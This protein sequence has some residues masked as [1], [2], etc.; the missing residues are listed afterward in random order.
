MSSSIKTNKDIESEIQ[1]LFNGIKEDFN[2]SRLD[3]LKTG[4]VCAFLEYH[5]KLYKIDLGNSSNGIENLVTHL[6]GKVQSNDPEKGYDTIKNKVN[7]T[8]FIKNS[9]TKANLLR[10]YLIMLERLAIEIKE[11]AE[12]TITPVSLSKLIASITAFFYHNS[13]LSSNTESELGNSVLSVYDFTAGWGVLL[14]AFYEIPS[15]KDKLFFSLDDSN[16][17]NLLIAKTTILLAANGKIMD[18]NLGQ[19]NEKEKPLAFLGK[20]F[21]D[22]LDN[23]KKLYD[24]VITHPPFATK[25]S[26][27]KN[28]LKEERKQRFSEQE[29]G[30]KV[31]DSTPVGLFIQHAVSLLSEGGIAA[32]V[33]PQGVLF[34]GNEKFLREYFVSKSDEIRLEGVIEIPTG[35]FIG[36]SIP[37]VLLILRKS[38][39]HAFS[40]NHKVVVLRT[41]DFTLTEKGESIFTDTALGEIKQLLLGGEPVWSKLRAVKVSEIEKNEYNLNIPRYVNDF[42]E[43]DILLSDVTENL[44]RVNKDVKINSEALHGKL[45]SLLH[46]GTKKE[47]QEEIKKM[48]EYFASRS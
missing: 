35:S 28:L 42:V 7:K 24:I 8:I 14:S 16:A 15:L 37:G 3:N 47:D 11:P 9:I 43:E 4:I 38:K 33:M 34:R 23:D 13:L 17:T 41:A 10:Y 20:K 45:A 1:V 22:E 18:T 36:S 27:V 39:K 46:E 2:T 32:V 12:G 48:M 40:E 19:K 30:G 5:I 21:E 25:I 31:T 6:K 44:A 29:Y 26:G